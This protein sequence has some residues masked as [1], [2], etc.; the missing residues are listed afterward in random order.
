M[1]DLSKTERTLL[2]VSPEV[3]IEHAKS[4]E[5]SLERSSNFQGLAQLQVTYT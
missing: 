2:Y 1:P 3:T 5:I 4:C